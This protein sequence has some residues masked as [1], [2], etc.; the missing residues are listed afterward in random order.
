M[1]KKQI[2]FL[3]AVLTSL[4]SSCTGI[5]E[6]TQPASTLSREQEVAAVRFKMDAATEIASKGY[7]GIKLGEFSMEGCS[8]R[9]GFGIL[10]DA[11]DARGSNVSGAVCGE[12]KNS[13]G[14]INMI[15]T[16]RR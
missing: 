9:H 13:D 7:T 3:I 10:F 4:L 8:S 6:K 2:I 12:F 14:N 1:N 11:K 5:Q 15:W 16:V